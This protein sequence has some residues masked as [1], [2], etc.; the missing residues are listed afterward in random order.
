MKNIGFY[1]IIIFMG[2]FALII[3]INTNFFQ[4]SIDY[5]GYIAIFMIISGLWGIIN[6]IIHKE[7]DWQ[8]TFLLLILAT[9]GVI[10]VISFLGI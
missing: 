3:S 7:F 5:F 8:T 2:I 9:A 1:I 4:G 6:G 10:L